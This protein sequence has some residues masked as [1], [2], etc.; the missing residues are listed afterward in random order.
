MS[1]RSLRLTASALFCKACDAAMP[2][3]E[4][5]LLVLP[6]KELYECLCSHCGAV[7][8]SRT[9]SAAE[10]VMRRE[11]ATNRDGMDGFR[12]GP[13]VRIL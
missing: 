1:Q 12:S 4:R 2:I 8:G 10:V 7:V 5:L 6:E 11:P 9:V 13:Q 3:R